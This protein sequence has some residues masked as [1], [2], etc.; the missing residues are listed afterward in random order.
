MIRNN[1]SFLF[2]G[3]RGHRPILKFDFRAGYRVADKFGHH[4]VTFFGR[5]LKFQESSEEGDGLM[6]ET[7]VKQPNLS[8]VR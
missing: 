7:R 4:L 2:L 8:Q 5:F 3:F 1:E 6:A